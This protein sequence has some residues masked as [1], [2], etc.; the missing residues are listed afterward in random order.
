MNMTEIFD[1]DIL[2]GVCDIEEDETEDYYYGRYPRRHY[3]Y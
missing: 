3:E 2:T 1:E